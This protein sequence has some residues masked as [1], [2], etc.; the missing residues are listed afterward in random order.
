MTALFPVQCGVGMGG[1]DSYF[2]LGCRLS[3]KLGLELDN[4]NILISNHQIN[5]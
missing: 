1:M 4:V 3:F 2:F 5:I